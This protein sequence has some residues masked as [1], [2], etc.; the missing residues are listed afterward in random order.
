MEFSDQSGEYTT[1]CYND[2]PSQGTATPITVPTGQATLSA[3]NAR[4]ELGEDGLGEL[5]LIL[6]H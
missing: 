5:L 2:K 1:Q 6:Q 4:S 3:I